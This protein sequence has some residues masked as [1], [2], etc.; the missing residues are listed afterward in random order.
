MDAENFY[1][2]LYDAHR[3]AIN[4]PYYVDTVDT[5]IPDPAAWDPIGV[6]E[7]RRYDGLRPAH[8]SPGAARCGG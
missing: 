8:R 1:I 5:D 2:A 4:F 7:A 6:G 3:G